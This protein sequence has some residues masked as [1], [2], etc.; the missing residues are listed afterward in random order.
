MNEQ[1]NQNFESQEVQAIDEKN[2]SGKSKLLSKKLWIISAIALALV[3][4][5]IVAIILIVDIANE[6]CSH[7]LTEKITKEATCGESGTKEF[8]CSTC[9]AWWT[10]T[11]TDS[12]LSHDWVAATCTQLKT[13]K[14]CQSIDWASNYASHDY[15]EATCTEV[16]TC[17]LCGNRGIHLAEHQYSETDGTCTA[18]GYGVKF[19]LPQTPVEI[20]YTSG[21]TVEKK[22]EIQSIKV[23]RIS[24]SKYEI[25]FIVE[26]TYHKKGNSYSDTAK[27]GWKLYDEDGMVVKSGTGSSD[28]SITVGEKSKEVITFWVG[29]DSDELQNGKTYRLE[30]LNIG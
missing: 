19:I 17:K 29:A 18:C 12:S 10:E 9:G 3:A 6:P 23:N 21:S 4:A 28:A 13:C 1:N 20:S 22:C 27:F 16:A 30:L 25:T 26:S 2:I 15:S 5:I 8:S 24:T 11:Y 7:V 14:K